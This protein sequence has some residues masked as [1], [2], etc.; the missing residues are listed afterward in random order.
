MSEA[1][2]ASWQ[3]LPE[4]AA[5][6]SPQTPG[7]ITTRLQPRKVLWDLPAAEVGRRSRQW[8]PA[9]EIQSA[10]LVPGT[11]HAALENRLWQTRS[12]PPGSFA[13]KDI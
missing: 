6:G 12:I 9:A 1:D 8:E 7:R 11:Y 4:R 3:M 13:R 5:R 10:P 2:R